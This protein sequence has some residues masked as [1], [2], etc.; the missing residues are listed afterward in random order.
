MIDLSRTR[1]EFLAEIN[2]PDPLGDPVTD[3]TDRR[4]ETVDAHLR[5]C[6]HAQEPLFSLLKTV[7]LERFAVVARLELV[8]D[9][10]VP[11]KNALGN[12]FKHGNGTD[13][14]KAIS[15]EIVLTGKGALIAVTDEGS[16]FDVAL[17]F[18]RFQGQESYFVNYGAGFRNLH[19]A[20][21]TVSYENGGRTVLLCFRPE[22]QNED[23]E[24]LFPA[25]EPLAV[26][27]S[28][29]EEPGVSPDGKHVELSKRA[30][31]SGSALPKVLDPEWVQSSLSAELPEFGKDG[32]RIES[33]RVYAPSGCAGDDCGNRYVLRVASRNGRLEDTRILTGRVHA[34]AAAAT[35]DFKAATKLH[36]ANISNRLRIPRPVGRLSGEPS[37][38]LYDFDPWM[39]LWEYSTCHSRLKTLRRIAKRIGRAL[40]RLHWSPIVF[41]GGEPERVGEELLAMMERAEKHLQSLPYGPGLVNRFHASARRLENRAVFG[42]QGIPAPIHG[43]LGWDCIYYGVEGRFYLYRF[44]TCRRSDPGLDLGGFAADLLRFTLANHDEEACHICLD[45]FLGNYNSEA[46]HAMSKDELLTYTVLALVERLRRADPSAKAGVG[47]LLAALDIALTTGPSGTQSEVSA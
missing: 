38:V 37:L 22:A 4:A 47:Q 33:C 31:I 9:L 21:A 28:P 19:R 20:M 23:R 30:K 14:A 12:A 25:P 15:V 36:D 10:L 6:S 3:L 17:T 34:T 43:A 16:G 5:I 41:P 18:Q 44:E 26:G 2:A 8:R 35:S 1:A 40:Q 11:L 27:I 46:A 13:A 29:A 32:A 45:D 39:N 7:L 42:G 24:S